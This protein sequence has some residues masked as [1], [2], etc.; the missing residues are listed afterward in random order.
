MKKLISLIG[1]LAFALWMVPTTAVAGECTSGLCGTPDQSGGG[2]GCAS[3]ATGGAGVLAVMLAQAEPS[4]GEITP[5][6]GH[7]ISQV[8]GG[9]NLEL[10][11][12]LPTQ[13]ELE[14][15][16]TDFASGI[17]Y[18]ANGEFLEHVHREDL[19]QPE[20]L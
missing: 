10:L 2:C 13:L 6:T 15:P 7:A 19:D 16:E 12:S 3:G 17:T 4:A 14:P 18:E 5:H 9:L 20:L 11:Q 8:I 1:A